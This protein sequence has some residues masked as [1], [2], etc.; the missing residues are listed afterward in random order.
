MSY[1]RHS[2]NRATATGPRTGCRTGNGEK[3]SSSQ[4]EPDYVIKS[5]VAYV[6][7]LHLLCDNAV[8]SPLGDIGET[9]KTLLSQRM[10]SMANLLGG[11]LMS[12]MKAETVSS[13]ASN[14]VHLV[15]QKCFRKWTDTHHASPQH[16]NISQPHALLH[17]VWWEWDRYSGTISKFWDM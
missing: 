5:A 10:G 8:R 15:R 11:W 2:Y 4:A 14:I 7:S 17:S 3:L 13:D 1:Y 9:K 6:V 16:I 12:E